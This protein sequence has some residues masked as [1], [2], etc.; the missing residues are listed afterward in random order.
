MG[1]STVCRSAS[2][3]T[4]ATWSTLASAVDATAA[5][6][7][8]AA[9]LVARA[10]AAAAALALAL[11]I[12]LGVLILLTSLLDDWLAAWPE[13]E[14]RRGDDG[15][16]LPAGGVGVGLLELGAGVEVP[17]RPIEVRPDETA[18]GAVEREICFTG[19][20]VLLPVAGGLG[21]VELELAAGARAAA[22]RGAEIGARAAVGLL[23]VGALVVDAFAATCTRGVTREP[24]TPVSRVSVEVGVRLAR[25]PEAAAVV[26]LLEPFCT[27]WPTT[28]GLPLVEIGGLWPVEL[29]AMVALGA[30]YLEAATALELKRLLGVTARA[31]EVESALFV[32]VVWLLLLVGSAPQV[33]VAALLAWRLDDWLRALAWAVV[34]V[35]LDVAWVRLGC[36]DDKAVSGR[37]PA[38][39]DEPVWLSLG[40]LKLLLL[41]M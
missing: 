14:P 6:T 13:V 23:G 1:R 28:L 30:L 21:R 7:A 26:G 39:T 9:T 38:P 11:S 18:P 4:W 24:P 35:R 19:D 3:G 16:V 37:T 22:G 29:V 36:D 34:A 20:L 8:T 41:A 5:P 15:A 17:V 12:A 2:S 25:P 27:E 32:G 33:A 40:R 31:D 10:A